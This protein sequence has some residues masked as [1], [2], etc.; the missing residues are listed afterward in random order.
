MNYTHKTVT[1]IFK[2][3]A[4]VEMSGD[5]DRIIQ[6]LRGHEFQAFMIVDEAKA[7]GWNDI[8]KLRE[9]LERFKI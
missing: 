9:A 3:N 7:S 8:E 4:K 6:L 5:I 1:I 2:D